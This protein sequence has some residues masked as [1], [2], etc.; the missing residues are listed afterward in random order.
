VSP[1]TSITYLDT[2]AT[3]PVSAS[4]A[5][6]VLGLMTE[7]FGNAGS[8]THAWGA[9]AKRRLQ[10]ARESLAQ[11]AG[12]APEEVIF[13]S[14]ATESDNLA[15]LGLARGSSGKDRRHIVSCASEHKAVLEPLETLAKEGFEVELVPPGRDG[16]IDPDELLRSVR[17]DT[18]LVSLMLVNNETGVVQPVDEIARELKESTTLF[19]VDAA[20]GFAKPTGESLAQVD[21]ISISGHKLGAPKGVGALV[22]RKRGWS[23]P[24]LAPIMFGGGQERGL[25]PGT[26]PV[27]LA[28][29]LAAAASELSESQVEW[30]TACAR[31]RSQLLDALNGVPHEINGA[32]DRSVPHIINLWFPGVDA[33]ALI[34][35]VKDFAAIATGSACTSA[36][37]TPSHVLLSMGLREDRA[38]QSV[39]LSWWSDTDTSFIAPFVKTVGSLSIG[40]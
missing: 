23:K 3:T 15:L 16:L 5:Q 17:P 1:E 20:Q 18:L 14:G 27:A 33:E 9:E 24:A 35:N 19:H 2:A 38:L 28:A 13:T 26:V 8:R 22:A 31:L 36:E 25:R 30:R 7:E 34:V 10:Q 39:R 12:A 4:V 11:V 37:F 29:G 6:L 40:A 32:P 21:L